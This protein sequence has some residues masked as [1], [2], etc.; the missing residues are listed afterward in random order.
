MADLQIFKNPEFGAIRTIERNGEPWFVG[1]DVAVALGYKDTVNALKSHVDAEDK[2][3]WQITTPSGKQKMAIINES[4]L[5]SL[6]LSSKLPDAKRFKR[7]VTSEVIPSIRKNGGYLTPEKL[8]EVLLKPDTIIQLAQ[9]LKIEQEKRKA[10]ESRIEQDKPKVLF[11][12]AVS[13]SKTSILVGELAKILKQNGV[14]TGEKRLFSWLRENGYLIRRKGTDH[15]MPTQRSVEQG[16]F[17]IKETAV[18]HSDG[19]VSVNK[20]PKVTGK[21]QAYFINLFLGEKKPA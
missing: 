14:D 1:K 8:E 19:H 4:G 10:L 3:G 2:G 7:W 13:A 6:V 12:D 16:L 5:Y 11:S 17:T 20:T 18:T 15:N 9:N 21:G